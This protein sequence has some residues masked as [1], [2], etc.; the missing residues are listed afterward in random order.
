MAEKFFWS[1]KK[2]IEEEC[3][4]LSVD[5]ADVT[6]E[7]LNDQ[8]YLRFSRRIDHI[9]QLFDRVSE[10]NK[11]LVLDQSNPD[12]YRI[13]EAKQELGG[14][15]GEFNRLRN[16]VYKRFAKFRTEKETERT[17]EAPDAQDQEPGD[18]PMEEEEPPEEDP[19]LPDEEF[20][21]EEKRNA[22][23]AE[24]RARQKKLAE[25][26]RK[27]D[28]QNA[29]QHRRE[30]DAYYAQQ[31]QLR[32]E[33]MR[34]G[35]AVQPG[36]DISGADLYREQVLQEENR[37]RAD[38]QQ[39]SR[40]Q[41]ENEAMRRTQ[42]RLEQSQRFEHLDSS[43]IDMSREG[44]GHKDGD[45]SL[46]HEEHT[47][48]YDPVYDK[49]QCRG[50]SPPDE[51][52]APSRRENTEQHHQPQ[53]HQ[54]QEHPAASHIGPEPLYEDR[55]YRS[56]PYTE[57]QRSYQAENREPNVASGGVHSLYDRAH[58]LRNEPNRVASST[59]P[60][61]SEKQ[62]R[63]QGYFSHDNGDVKASEGNRVIDS[64]R[65]GPHA[66]ADQSQEKA[67]SSFVPYQFTPAG[68]S[69]VVSPGH[70]GW[71]QPSESNAV[72]YSALMTNRE[73]EKAPLQASPVFETQ[74]RFNLDRAH[75]AY[76]DARGTDAAA[77]AAHEYLQQRE[78]LSR[79]SSA[80]KQGRIQVQDAVIPSAEPDMPTQSPP[81]GPTQ[82]AGGS[83]A[84]YTLTPT[85]TIG[86]TIH[87]GQLTGNQYVYHNPGLRSK[88]VYSADAPMVVSPQYEAA[89]LG[90]MQSATAALNASIITGDPKAHAVDPVQVKLYT[91][92]YL[93]FQQAKRD[94]TVLVSSQST[95]PDLPD[96]ASWQQKHLSVPWSFARPIPHVNASVNVQSMSG[97]VAPG[98]PSSVASGHSQKAAE[99]PLTGSPL[100]KNPVPGGNALGPVGGS[101]PGRQLNGAPQGDPTPKGPVPGG[102]RPGPV[103]GNGSGSPSPKGQMP[104]KPAPGA[105]PK[106]MTGHSIGPNPNQTTKQMVQTA[107]ANIFGQQSKLQY[108]SMASIYAK[109]VGSRF[110]AYSSAAVV[111]FSRQMYYMSQK[112]DDNP[113]QTMEQGRYYITTAAG[114]ALA[115]KSGAPAAALAKQVAKASAVEFNLYGTKSLLTNKQLSAAVN[116]GLRMSRELDRQISGVQQQL[117]P[118]VSKM[119]QFL[120]KHP[121]GN[122]L[123][124]LDKLSR[125]EY[126]RLSA[127]LDGLQIQHVSVK[128]ALRLH[129]SQQTLRLTSKWDAE[130][131][132]NLEVNGKLPTSPRKLQEAGRE[133]VDQA[134]KAMKDKYKALAKVTDK[135]L[136]K[137]I[138]LLK[139]QGA[140]LKEQIRF[141]EGKGTALSQAERKLLLEL[142]QQSKDLGKKLGKLV[143][144]SK[145]RAKLSFT[146]KKLDGL[147]QDAYKNRARITNSLY[148][149]QSF[150][151]RPLRAGY[152]SNT[153]GL[154]RMIQISSNRYVHIL[155]K[156]SF[157]ASVFLTKTGMNLVVPGSAEAAS[158]ALTL[159]KIGVKTKV[160]LA[161]NAVTSAVKTGVK[162][163]AQ[164]AGKAISNAVPGG[165]KTG[166]NAVGRF[167]AG[168]YNTVATGIHNAVFQAKMWF[169]N[170]RVGQSLAALGR[171]NA[172]ATEAIKH[173][174]S[175]AKGFLLKALAVFV[176]FYLLVGVLTA[177]I[178][179]VGGGVGS[180]IIASPD[181]SEDGKIDLSAY[182]AVLSQKEAEFEALL[183]GY[184]ND[185]KYDNVTVNY[186]G[187][188][189]NT[190]EMLSMMAVRM[191]QELDM[192]KNPKVKEYL[193]SL[194]DDS[195]VIA[196]SER[197]YKCS[198]CKSYIKT[199]YVYV[200][201]EEL[202]REV[203]S[204]IY[205]PVL[206][207]YVPETK[208]VE[209]VY[210]TGHV[211]LTVNVTVL[212]FDQI[213]TAD[214]YGNAGQNAVPGAKIG[215]FTIT[216]YC[217]E[218]YPHICNAGPPYT[219]ASG[220]TPTPNRTIAVDRSVIPLGTHL[221]IDGMEYIAEDTGGAIKGN[222]ID[223]VVKTHQEALNKGKRQ[224]VPV[225]YPSYEGGSYQETGEWNG[226][227]EDNI[228]WCKLI[229]GMKWSQ[230]YTG[231][232]AY[233]GVIDSSELVVDGDYMW[234][235][236]CYIVTS[237]FGPRPAPVAGA[238]TFHKGVDLGCGI[239]T[240]VFAPADGTVTV[241][242]YQANGA[243]KYIAIDHG[244][245][246]VTRYLHLSEQMVSVGDKV[247]QGEIF[248]LT[249]NTG[250]GTGP[251]LHF[252]FI[253]NGTHIDPCVQ[254][255]GIF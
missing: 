137:E 94:G 152:E 171:F 16:Q 35:I 136:S 72:I 134:N 27:R 194:Y 73:E 220:T 118:M 66:G 235:V 83:G 30:E 211:D 128:K 203:L 65:P 240:P 174:L 168:K 28:R 149:L 214:S 10:V 135:S 254:Y 213:F 241:V 138:S 56:G 243:G 31:Q 160:D 163:S 20:V 2:E 255:S 156:K 126:V 183:N 117:A 200:Y 229:Y 199:E 74:M 150:I 68:V 29:D 125:R 252:E 142:K 184:R 50:S 155:V 230:I 178:G 55:S 24:R 191:S 198:G 157:K 205:D 103:G 249:G 95:L 239:G 33:A 226:W 44:I 250:I 182:S 147:I 15:Y 208:E 234:P 14:R 60:S 237:P 180:S 47:A 88:A 25:E 132:K 40:I 87:Q 42:E 97:H 78:A 116:N 228:E 206:E 127:Q 58:D 36:Q 102:N 218:K 89:I 91:D 146:Q 162:M 101:T 169:A 145:D 23:T 217:C 175:V 90:K 92:A 71:S 109:Q 22:K 151:L 246:V 222:R 186:T 176:L 153:E 207:K 9:Q 187:A 225:Y 210:C 21:P 53:H 123:N 45:P 233:N 86:Q 99:S 247:T 112:G 69:P 12:L 106:G 130:L 63:S 172:A 165:I 6:D 195:H 96:Y 236:D 108:Q 253:V 131:L 85:G 170:T 204:M 242:A 124:C 93:G 81:P 57:K 248:A 216:Y 43:H 114:L 110:Q 154:A 245:G 166:A 119:D 49:Q 232:Y 179:A 52:S 221:V 18:A 32:E 244:N 82:T 80:L 161:A 164:T 189:S 158:Q 61:H 196:T 148:A 38:A 144:L 13:L 188:I 107:V 37:Q 4:A 104:G 64:Y 190:K 177:I 77:D 181:V 141:L 121:D 133:I 11:K 5:I 84:I 202:D 1:L 167:V 41:Q 251:H 212:T 19:E 3:H 113:L 227:T 140:A 48:S 238:S 197:Q 129:Q 76:L 7:D 8:I 173:A 231:V 59:E 223:I 192:A 115:I 111:R 79:Y 224:N 193:S 201:D 75:M 219:T 185:P 143:G 70:G 122:A 51:K 100:P 62:E 39:A 159:A 120:L 67:A 34:K 46:A 215:D 54:P 139:S 209:V 98:G 17:I 105:V 26:G